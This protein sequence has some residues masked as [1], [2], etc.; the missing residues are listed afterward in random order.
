MG[1]VFSEKAFIKMRRSRLI[2]DSRILFVLDS[3]SVAQNFR[4]YFESRHGYSNQS[5]FYDVYVETQGNK[6]IE[7]CSKRYPSIVIVDVD[8]PRANS[9][10]VYARS[11]WSHPLFSRWM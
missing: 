10:M 7:I 9:K 6:A 4:D 11:G 3:A 8:S 5:E 1:G 2:P